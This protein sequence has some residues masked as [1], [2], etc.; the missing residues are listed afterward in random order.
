MLQGYAWPGNARELRNVV[1]RAMIVARGRHLRILLPD[2]G[3]P[4]TRRGETLASVEKDHIMAIL[5]ASG[6]QIE[7]KDGAAT[8]LG[9]TTRALTAR[10][11]Q[12]GIRLPDATRKSRRSS[13]EVGGELRAV[14]IT[15][16]LAKHSPRRRT[17]RAR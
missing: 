9:L 2:S 11:A 8:R 14:P 12:L 7:G 4:A 5:A 15:R 1:E 3:L 10:L 16:A 13:R 6:G 17:R